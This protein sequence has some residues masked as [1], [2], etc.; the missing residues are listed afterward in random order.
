MTEHLFGTNDK[1]ADSDGDGLSDYDEITGWTQD[2]DSV[3]IYTSPTNE[4]TDGDG[5]NDKKD[6][7]PTRREMFKDAS[8]YLLQVFADSLMADST[9]LLSLDSAALD[10]TDS[11]SVFVQAAY[12]HI[13]V[14]PNASKVTWVR[15]KSGEKML[16]AQP[17]VVGGKN[18][19]SFKT[20]KPLTVMK[21]TEVKIEVKS[22]DEDT[23]MAYSLSISSKLNAPTNLK[24]GKSAG[25]DEIRVMYDR[26]ED[27][28]V[29]GYVILRVK[30]K[31][32]HGVAQGDQLPNSIENGAKIS[33]GGTYK[34]DF[35]VII[36]STNGNEY[37]DAV[38]RGADY[39]CY[40]VF[41]YTT[42]GDS[43]NPVKVFSKGT[44][45]KFRN[46]GRLHL[47]ISFKDYGGEYNLD[48]CRDN[49]WTDVTLYRSNCEDLNDAVVTWDAYDQIA[50]EV[51]SGNTVIFLSAQDRDK[52]DKM[53]DAT[54][55]DI[56]I[57]KEGMCLKIRVQSDCSKVDFTRK[58]SWPYSSMVKD[59]GSDYRYGSGE[60]ASAPV[61]GENRFLVGKSGIKYNDENGK[62][63]DTCGGD[64]HAGYKFDI[65]YYWDNDEAFY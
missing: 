33:N 42:E 8:L 3:K 17:T 58:I 30:K 48:G 29:E 20:P 49:I 19:Y 15:L 31:E 23:V 62:C 13:K 24:L 63:G 35:K 7:E 2:G 47:E 55:Q 60:S 57:G 59:D 27:S 38:G 40:R 64:V 41:A 6:P 53:P 45:E 14:V 43:A 37:H 44:E 65:K 56:S 32:N 22:E 10:S 46:V 26:P 50:G 1:K 21:N 18:V 28:R 12:A 61:K 16:Y 39:Y 9:A 36:D 51:G 4:D 34:D 54:K 25:R 52:K 11:A 5:L